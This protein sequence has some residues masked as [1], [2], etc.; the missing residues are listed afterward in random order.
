MTLPKHITEAGEINYKMDIDKSGF[1]PRDMWEKDGHFKNSCSAN[2]EKWGGEWSVSP[3]WSKIVILGNLTSG[4]A[5]I[6]WLD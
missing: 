1:T 2:N 6:A 4:N 5:G 3:A